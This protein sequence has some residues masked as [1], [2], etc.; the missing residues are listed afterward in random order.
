MAALGGYEV[1]E[2]TGGD[3]EKF[4][5]K[6]GYIANTADMVGYPFGYI[7]RGYDSVLMKTVFWK[8]LKVDSAAS[9]YPGT[10][11]NVQDI[12]LHRVVR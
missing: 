6:A 10:P 11:A 8:S 4:G 7:M 5:A 9:D 2:T 12:V 1:V 3:G